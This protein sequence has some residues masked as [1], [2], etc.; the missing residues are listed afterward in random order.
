MSSIIYGSSCTST[1][2]V[3]AVMVVVVVVVV[4]VMVVIV[5]VIIVFSLCQFNHQLPACQYIYR[6]NNSNLSNPSELLVR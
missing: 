5:V 1:E 4:V 3:G 6:L 2:E